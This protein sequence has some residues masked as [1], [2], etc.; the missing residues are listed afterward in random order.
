MPILVPATPS[1]VSIAPDGSEAIGYGLGAYGGGGYG[2]S[3]GGIGDLPLTPVS[4]GSLPLVTATP[5]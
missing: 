4:P 2:T 3:A 5:N 1:S